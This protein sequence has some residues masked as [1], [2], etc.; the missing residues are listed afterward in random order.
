MTT[1]KIMT[2][3]KKPK[4]DKY[5]GY[6]PTTWDRMDEYNSLDHTVTEDQFIDW[7]ATIFINL[8]VTNFEQ[9]KDVQVYQI[10]NLAHANPVT[11]YGNWQT[12][13]YGGMFNTLGM[14]TQGFYLPFLPKE[15]F[16]NYKNLEARFD[17]IYAKVKEKYLPDNSGK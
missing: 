5:L 4:V 12:D 16:Q 11:F 6:L 9:A 14:Y 17:W 15:I 8:K 1:T 2:T 7:F 13:L 3:D 10:L